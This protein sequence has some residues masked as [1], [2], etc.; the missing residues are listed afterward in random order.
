MVVE[1]LVCI[2]VNQEGEKFCFEELNGEMKRW[3]ATSV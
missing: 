3:L 1:S 2:N